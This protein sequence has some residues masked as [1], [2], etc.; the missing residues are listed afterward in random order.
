LALTEITLTIDVAIMPVQARSG[1]RYGKAEI[2]APVWGRRGIAMD[3]QV[4]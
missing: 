4:F 1:T 2:T 3:D